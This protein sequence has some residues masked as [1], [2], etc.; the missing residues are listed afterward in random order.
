ME[1]AGPFGADQIAQ[2]VDIEGAG[3]GEVAHNKFDMTG[4]HHVE[5]RIGDRLANGHCCVSGGF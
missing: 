1:R 2:A 4:A 3:A 5:W